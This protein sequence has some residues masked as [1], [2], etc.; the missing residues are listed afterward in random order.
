MY[1]WVDENLGGRLR[2]YGVHPETFERQMAH[3]ARSG[4]RCLTLDTLRTVL[5][6]GD[7]LPRQSFVLTFDDGY[8]D[9]ERTVLPVLERYGFKATVFV[10]TDEVG[11]S[12]RWD[13]PRGDPP[14]A[15]LGWRA[16][17]R[18]DGETL[19]FESHS[20]T[21]PFLNDLDEPSAVRE[22]L[23][24]KK[25]L[26][27]ELGRPV[28][29]FCYPHGLFNLETERLVRE[30]GYLCAATDIRG[31]NGKG[32]DPLR[33]RRVMMTSEDGLAGFLLKSRTGHDLRSAARAL[34]GRQTGAP[35]GPPGMTW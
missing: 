35:D 15:L 1:H 10:V 13:A 29:A 20:S 27:D 26:E 32:T 11:G 8:A 6:T 22:I 4:W 28:T 18:L 16:I 5:E 3:F 30:A 12:N 14:R 19:L 31:R 9:L 25:R 23:G 2:R 34:V 7:D 17:R 24:S 21:H 33:I